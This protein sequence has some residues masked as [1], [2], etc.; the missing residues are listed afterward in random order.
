MDSFSMKIPPKFNMERSFERFKADV[1]AW[2]EIT[3]VEKEKQGILVTL[4][5]PDTGKYGDLRGKVM[6]TVEAKIRG[7]DGRNE[8]LKFLKKTL[9]RTRLLTS[10]R[11]SKPSFT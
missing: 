1:E 9:D 6:E 7:L 10:L 3:S 5:L 11:R 8:V 4:N 2:A